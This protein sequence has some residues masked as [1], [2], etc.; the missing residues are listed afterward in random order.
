MTSFYQAFFANTRRPRS[1]GYQLRPLVPDPTNNHRLV[2]GVFAPSPRAPVLHRGS[3]FARASNCL[4]LTPIGRTP[5][6]SQWAFL[7]PTVAAAVLAGLQLVSAPES[8]QESDQPRIHAFISTLQGVRHSPATLHHPLG[9]CA[10]CSRQSVTFSRSP[11]NSHGPLKLPLRLACES[12][13]SAL[14]P[15]CHPGFARQPPIFIGP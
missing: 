9:P 11:V 7:A 8:N 14:V 5:L 6:R 1:S 4:D 2:T 12:R 10:R 15:P 13:C 3:G